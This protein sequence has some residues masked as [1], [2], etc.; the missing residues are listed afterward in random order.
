MKKRVGIL[1]GSFDPVHR[2]HV[3][4][5][6]SFL[7]SGLID[8]LLVLL[9]PDP[10]HKKNQKKTDFSDRFEM[11]KLA[12]E[13]MENITVSDLE[14]KLPGPSYTIQTIEYLQKVN[15]NTLF[16]LCLGQDSLQNFHK[17]HRYKDILNKVDLLVAERPGFGDSGVDPEILEHVI[18]VE[19]KPYAASSTSIRLSD[20]KGKELLPDS[21]AAYIE[22]NNL[23]RS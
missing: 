6:G 12:F 20:G 23:Y 3:R 14:K 10:P 11:L 16:Y 1:G 17:W 18:F 9:A 13:K 21:V 19:H 15:F 4:I 7:K 5:A 22:K 8:E 2:G